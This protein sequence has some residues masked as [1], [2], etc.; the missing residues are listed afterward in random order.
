MTLENGRPDQTAGRLAKEIRVYD[1]L[2]GLNVS[3]QRVD[4]EPA[5]TMEDCIAVDRVLGATMCKNLLLCNYV[6][7]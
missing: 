7:L 5:M 4:H 2:D 6:V 1:M 3:Y